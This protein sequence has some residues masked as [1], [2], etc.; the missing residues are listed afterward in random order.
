MNFGNDFYN[1]LLICVGGVF[2]LTLFFLT[3]LS[4]F[5][6][7]REKVIGVD[8]EFTDFLISKIDKIERALN[9]VKANMIRWQEFSEL[10]F[11][12]IEKGLNEVKKIEPGQFTDSYSVNDTFSDQNISQSI[13]SGITQEERKDCLDSESLDNSSSNQKLDAIDTVDTFELSENI[14][15]KISKNLDKDVSASPVPFES[16][17]NETISFEDLSHSDINEETTRK[18]HIF[19]LR[20]N[21]SNTSSVSTGLRKTR[22][23]LFSKIKGRSFKDKKQHFQELFIRDFLRH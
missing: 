12:E 22:E 11:K 18:K 14:K 13:P 3:I 8:K 16:D 4:L 15:K 17:E 1:L 10:E 19:L 6:R 2:A 5:K 9:D 21:L 23:S 20:D 7:K